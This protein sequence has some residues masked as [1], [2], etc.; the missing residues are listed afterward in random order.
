MPEYN[1]AYIRVFCRD[2]GYPMAVIQQED[3]DGSYLIQVTCWQPNCLL[4]GFTLS[5]E[6]YKSLS[7][8]QLEAY[9][10]IN[11]IYPP[12]YIRAEEMDRVVIKKVFLLYS[13]Q[14]ETPIIQKLGDASFIIASI[15]SLNREIFTYNQEISRLRN[16]LF[17]IE[18]IDALE[19]QKRTLQQKVFFLTEQYQVVAREIK[20]MRQ[21][22]LAY[23]QTPYADY[24]PGFMV[25]A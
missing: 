20:E 2:C 4:H 22:R 23:K 13:S 16:G 8:F 1:A 14:N 18:D 19:F 3:L 11:R 7:D 25:E 9:R 5:L 12:Q 21:E 15:C 6:R 17:A 24:H 10:Q